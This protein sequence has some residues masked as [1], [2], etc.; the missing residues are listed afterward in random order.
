MGRTYTEEE[1]SRAKEEVLNELFKRPD[2]S[3][4]AILA[5]SLNRKPGR[6]PG[7]R[8]EPPAATQQR[9]MRERAAF[10]LP[11]VKTA[12]RLPAQHAVQMLQNLATSVI[13][14]LSRR[15]AELGIYLERSTNTYH[16]GQKRPKDIV[17]WIVANEF[18]V[19]QP[20]TKKILRGIR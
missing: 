20:I 5:L 14:G 3:T 7:V 8:S 4:R 12:R 18:K 13:P 1:F 9:Q 15:L 11:Q 19:S 17:I 16:V 10:L 6:K 2:E